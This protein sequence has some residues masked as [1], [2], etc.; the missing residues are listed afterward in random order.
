MEILQT[1][2][3]AKFESIT[4][5][6]R[7]S[8]SKVEKICEDIKNGFNMLQYTPI[9]VSEGNN[10]LLIVD[11]QHRFE[12]SKIMEQP[13]YYVICRDITLQQIAILNSRS[14]KWT[15]NDFLNCYINLGI[16]DYVQLNE[17]MKKHKT[18]IRVSIDLLMSNTV[19]TSSADAFQNG[20]FKCNYLE[21]ATALV[22]LTDSLFNLFVFS[23]DRYLIGAVQAIQK[24]A[25]VDW[26]RLENKIKAKPN[27]MSR[28]VDIKNY[29][30]NIER[31]YNDG[32]HNRTLLT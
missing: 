23:K 32:I 7:I 24:K 18:N 16:N 25:V 30:L 3:Y 9:I 29:I 6:R 21:E 5:N 26:K 17:F 8:T 15:L 22:E 27:L 1:T 13:V 2:D 11:G 4:G 10:K 14:S 12:V 20:L 19:K 28:Q 31:I